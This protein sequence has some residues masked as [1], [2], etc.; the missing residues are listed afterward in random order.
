MA[1][2]I[3]TTGVITGLLPSLHADSTADLTYW[4]LTDLIQW[5]DEG[6]KR[7][8]RA[9]A[10]FIERD[11]SITT[12]VGTASYALPERQDTTLHVSVGTTGVRPA[13]LIELEMRD[14]TFQTTQGTPDHWYEDGQGWNVGL[15]PAP[16]SVGPVALIMAA[17]PPAL[18]AEQVNT[19]VQAPGPFAGYLAM[20]AL[21]KAYGREGE[22]E[23]PDVAQHCAARCD[24]YEKIF[25]KYYGAGL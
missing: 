4:T 23:M 11:T 16:N 14:P 24:M 3:N 22:M 2:E 5:M 20:Y 1:G 21:A 13:S 18:D 12:A 8:A 15:S 7:M 17:W 25:E 10:C 19:L 6:C 9:A